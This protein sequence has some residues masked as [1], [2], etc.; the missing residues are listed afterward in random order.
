MKAVVLKLRHDL[1]SPGGL[2]K[3]HIAGPFPGFSDSVAPWG[4]VQEFALEGVSW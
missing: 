4:G 2:A 1:E 3:T